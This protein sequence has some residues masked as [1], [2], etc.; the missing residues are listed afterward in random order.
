M[1]KKFK[2]EITT[3]DKKAAIIRKI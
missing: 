3:P 1:Y 2:K